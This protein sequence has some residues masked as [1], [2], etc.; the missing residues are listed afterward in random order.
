ML[1]IFQGR[2]LFDEEG[3][4]F[5]R[6]DVSFREHIAQFNNGKSFSALAVFMCISLH[7][8]EHGWAWPG[9]DRIKEYTGI[10]SEAALTGA[11]AM[12]RKIKIDGNRVFAH[13]RQKDPESQKW[14]RSA[15]LIFPDKAHGP[16]PFENM[17]EYDPLEGKQVSETHGFVYLV[18]CERGYKIGSTQ[19]L[20]HRLHALRS[21]QENL[22]VV[23]TH[24]SDNALE[25]EGY[26]HKFFSQKHIRGDWF[27]L[28]EGDLALFSSAQEP[29]IVKPLVAQPNVAQLSQE[30]EPSKEEK[31]SA[32]SASPPPPQ[33]VED[34]QDTQEDQPFASKLTARDIQRMTVSEAQAA[35][36]DAN[37]EDHAALLSE[38]LHN[39]NMR[40]RPRKTMIEFLEYKLTPP[41]AKHQALYE[42]FV[43]ILS[44][45]KGDQLEAIDS[46]TMKNAS[47]LAK[48]MRKVYEVT[49]DDL[50][51]FW[52]WWRKVPTQHNWRRRKEDANARPFPNEIKKA[53]PD[54]I[55]YH[56]RVQAAAAAA[57]AQ[58]PDYPP[59]PEAPGPVQP[60]RQYDIPDNPPEALKKI[61]A[62]APRA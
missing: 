3:S 25:L 48:T 6:L 21:Q 54:F 38:V 2:G 11:L 47:S 9:R 62:G 58:Q 34:T 36:A 14:G 24:E 41:N 23:A 1:G 28:D 20:S 13:Y 56:T 4:V 49:T 53:W 10:K 51:A 45:A 30:E 31:S 35:L 43:W 16:A 50:R 7:V 29:P 42:A 22:R 59:L 18:S 37:Y 52:E 60:T 44:G 57:Q 61:F 46:G 26:W 32:A 27:D 17:R 15:Y 8:N 40:A 12:L 33:A 19:K 5:A 39:E 55:D